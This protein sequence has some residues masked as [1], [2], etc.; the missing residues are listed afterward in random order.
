MALPCRSPSEGRDRRGLE[1]GMSDMT[2]PTTER[3]DIHQHVT[4][5]I[6]AFIEQGTGKAEM[7]WN[8]SGGGFSMPD[9]IETG[10]LY[11][12]VNVLGLWASACKAGYSSG[13]WGTYRQW[14]GKGCQV[15]KG[16]RG[17]LVVF[18]KKIDAQSDEGDEAGQ[19]S[20]LFARSSWVFNAEQVEGY[21][22][23][24]II[25]DPTFD[26]I[27]SAELFV[28]STRADIRHG[29]TQAY[30][31]PATDSI[32]M[33]DRNRFTGTE[34]MS[35]CEGYY[36]TLLHELTHWT[37]AKQRLDRE[38]GKRF[39]DNAYAMEEL[40]AELGAAF[41][42]ARLSITPQVREDHASYVGHWLKVM[43]EDKKAIFTAA[44]KAAQATDYL[45]ALQPEAREA[46]A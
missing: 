4:D 44:S 39:G 3:L 33:P 1:N 32:Q 25:T 38:L 34:S 20:R 12:G 29:G 26:P 41:L 46:A 28:S 9:N 40:V 42:C 21:Q 7:P 5:Q 13:T 43:K 45:F 27:Q 22:P 31:R 8:R 15:R 14:Q 6:I 23:A 11:R 37:S 35:A 19:E 24:G 16:E 10:N 2:K 18:Y 36:A 17:S 30:Y